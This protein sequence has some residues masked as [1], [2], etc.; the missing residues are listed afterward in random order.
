[1][2]KNYARVEIISLSDSEATKANITQKLT[3]LVERVQPGDIV[4]VY[5]AGHGTAQQN[6]FY[7]IP[8]D[9]GYDGPRATLDEA[10]LQSILAHSISD[11]ELEK[12]FEKI[13]AG[14]ILLVIDACNSGQALEAEEKR[15]GPMNSKGLAQLAYEKGMYILAAAQSYQAA[16]EA[17]KLGHGFLT[18]ALVEDGLKG[19]TADREPKDGRI[20][21]R[22]WLNYATD[23]VPRMQEENTLEALRGR[24]RFINFV[25]DGTAPQGPGN[26]S[27]QRPRTFYRR[28]LESNPLVVAILGATAPQ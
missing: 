27:V 22:E 15:G 12:A 5:F 23:Q 25:G 21:L 14:Q 18:Y 11:R 13:D 20:E 6:R 1:M 2:L 16:Q 4:I 10:G 17:E 26:S 7:L 24:G 8:H 28:E 3:Q 9:L 19:G